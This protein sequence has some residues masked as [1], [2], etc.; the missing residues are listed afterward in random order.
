MIERKASMSDYTQHNCIAELIRAL[1]RMALE[2]RREAAAAGFLSE[3]R[4]IAWA[5]EMAFL[6]AA[7]EAGKARRAARPAARCWPI[8]PALRKKA[9]GIG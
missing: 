4:D 3:E 5:R 7:K 6:E 8:N 1:V 9:L 2:A